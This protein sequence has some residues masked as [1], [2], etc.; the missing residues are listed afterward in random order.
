MLAVLYWRYR[1]GLMSTFLAISGSLRAASLNTRLLHALPSLAPRDAQIAQF[2]ISQVPLYNQDLDT[3]DAPAV[4]QAMRL[5]VQEAD[6]IIL[7]TPEHNHTIPA[8]TKNV[9][10][11]MSRPYQNGHLRHKN[12]ALFVGSIGPTSGTYCLAHTKDLLELLE[13]TVVCAH[14]IGA[15]HEKLDNVGGV[16]TVVDEQTAQMIREGLSQL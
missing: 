11:W 9:I 14:A 15:L 3:E 12:I 16:E 6:G 13:N 4:V 7:V 1:C 2:D 5:A 8:A 10:D